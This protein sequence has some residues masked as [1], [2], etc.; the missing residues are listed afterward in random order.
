MRRMCQY[1]VDNFMDISTIHYP[2]FTQFI[3]H[4]RTHNTYSGTDTRTLKNNFQQLSIDLS[5]VFDSFGTKTVGYRISIARHGM[6]CKSNV[7]A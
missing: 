7:I 1:R 6:I 2:V 3:V 4:V 5:D